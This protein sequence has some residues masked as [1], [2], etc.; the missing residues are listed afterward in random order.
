MNDEPTSKT[1]SGILDEMIGFE[2]DHPPDG[3]P[4]VRMSQI[5]ELCNE[6]IAA[7]KKCE[8]LQRAAYDV[9]SAFENLGITK[10][11]NELL[12]ARKRCEKVLVKLRETLQT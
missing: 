6:L 7:Q 3:W 8:E 2:A 10:N 11:A 4:A 9:V 5:S 1:H 12:I